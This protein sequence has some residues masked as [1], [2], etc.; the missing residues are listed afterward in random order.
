MSSGF[1][2]FYHI[3]EIFVKIKIFCKFGVERSYKHIVF[4]CGNYM[5]VQLTQNFY[6]IADTVN[7][8]CTD[9]YKRKRFIRYFGDNDFFGKTVDLLAVCVAPYSNIIVPMCACSPSI[10]FARTISPAQVPKT[11]IPFSIIFLIGSY[12]SSL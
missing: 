1:F 4:S 11:G 2:L 8:R 7:P 5:T 3:Y 9:K 12:K 6:V 10:F